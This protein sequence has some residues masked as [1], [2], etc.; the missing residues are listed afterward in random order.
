VSAHAPSRHRSSSSSLPPLDERTQEALDVRATSTRRRGWVVRRALLAADIVGLLVAFAIAHVFGGNH[1]VTIAEEVLLFLASLP[2]WAVLAKL[3]RLY[4]LDEESTDHSTVDDIV[5]VLQLVTIGTWGF[6]V[7]SWLLGLGQHD[8][9]RLAAFWLTAIVMIVAFRVVAR[10]LSRRSVAYLQNTVIVGAGDI[11][12]LVGRKILQHPEYGLNLIGF[13]DSDPRDRRSEVEGVQLLGSPERLPELIEDLG[14][15]RIVIAF[16]NDRAEETIALVRRLR[17]LD[18]QIDIVPRLFDILGPKVSVH[19]IEALPL[20]SLPSARI[21][22]SSQAI[23]RAIDIVGAIVGLVLTAPLFAVIAL[24]VKRDSPG[25]IFFRQIRLGMNMREFETLK[26]RTMKVNTDTAA[27]REFIKQTMTHKASTTESGV[28]KLDRSDAITRSGRWLRKT[29]L[30]ELP[31]LINV[32]RGDMSLVGPRP[33]LPYE[34]E[35]FEEHHF[36]RFLV[37][38]G[39]TGLWQVT[40][41]AHSTFGEALDMDVVYARGWSLGLDLRLLCRTPLQLLRPGNTR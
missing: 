36:E 33:C 1:G 20:L 22:R 19:T 41:R 37:P 26:F 3:H 15:E 12:Q 23:K 25:P 32:L 29:S 11:G 7:A 16:S 10:T 39:V 28:Y 31:Q 30:D 21:P 14:I 6:F 17:S 18:V 9:P 4:D 8:A 34:T 27:H 40:A 24:L 35:F 2:V 38:G 5:G 13:L